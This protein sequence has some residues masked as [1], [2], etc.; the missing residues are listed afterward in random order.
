LTNNSIAL[1]IE[2]VEQ[3]KQTGANKMLSGLSTDDLLKL[4]AKLETE[5]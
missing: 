5:M 2:N 3:T 1:I 4:Q